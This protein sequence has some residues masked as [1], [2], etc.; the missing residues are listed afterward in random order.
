MVGLSLS[1]SSVNNVW[2]ARSGNGPPGAAGAIDWQAAGR[3]LAT[4]AA[5]AGPRSPSWAVLG[6]VLKLRAADVLHGH[7][8]VPA[9]DGDGRRHGDRRRAGFHLIFPVS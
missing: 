8:R 9:P 7:G 2:K 3:A 1:A 5:F 4:W 6:F